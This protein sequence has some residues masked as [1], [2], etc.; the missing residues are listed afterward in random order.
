MQD[1]LTKIFQKAKYEP[2][3][4]LPEKVWHRILTRDKHITQFKL[5]TF[6][7]IGFVSL[8]GLVPAFKTLINDFTQ[9]GFYEYSSLIFSDSGLIFS[10]WKEYML[11]LAESLPMISIIFTLSLVFVLFLSLRYLVKQISKNQ[12]TSLKTLSF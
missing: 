10:Y 11:S 4:N 12:L 3:A 7:S 1:K 8:A 5:W 9:S 6:A 2:S